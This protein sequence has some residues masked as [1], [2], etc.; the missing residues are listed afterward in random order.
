MQVR[1]NRR[2]RFLGCVGYPGCKGRR[3]LDGEAPEEVTLGRD[4]DTD[5]PVHLKEGP[6]GPYVQLGDGEGGQKPKRASLPK[7]WKIEDVGLPEAL[8]LLS[9]PRTV[10]LDPKTGEEVVA[11]LGRYGPFVRRGKTF[12]SLANAAE[13]FTVGLEEALRRVKKQESGPSVLRKLG[14]HPESGRDL[15]VLSGR[16]GPYV[17][18]G[19]VNASLGKGTAPE[20]LTMEQAVKRLAWAAKRKRSGGRRARRK[21]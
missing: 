17:T 12:A 7:D 11:G 9:L 3:A 16:Y 15:Q 8:R 18:D 21:R 1:F 19:K 2:G 13:M 14:P 4:P 10:G 6:Y 5:L 20:D